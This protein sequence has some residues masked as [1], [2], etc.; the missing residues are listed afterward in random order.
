[1]GQSNHTGDRVLDRHERPDVKAYM[2]CAVLPAAFGGG[3]IGATYIHDDNAERGDYELPRIGVSVD[4][5]VNINACKHGDEGGSTCWV[6]GETHETDSITPAH[7]RE[8][9]SFV[10]RAGWRWT[11]NV[12]GIHGNTYKYRQPDTG[13]WLLDNYKRYTH[14]EGDGPKRNVLPDDY[15]AVWAPGGNDRDIVRHIAKC[16]GADWGEC[17]QEPRCK[18][19]WSVLTRNATLANDV[20][21]SSGD[22]GAVVGVR[23]DRFDNYARQLA[24]IMQVGTPIYTEC[25]EGGRGNGLHWGYPDCDICGAKDWGAQLKGA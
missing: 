6:Y 23:H 4:A 20:R 14:I 2:L 15:G 25:A 5:K 3:A 22:A 9:G 18:L 17:A 19:T 24:A 16:E 10:K 1:M 11:L 13:Q 12:C 21:K 7:G 8:T